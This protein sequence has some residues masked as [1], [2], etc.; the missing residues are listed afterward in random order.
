MNYLILALQDKENELN[1]IYKNKIY[2]PRLIQIIDN[3]LEYVSFRRE[4][5][6]D[7]RGDRF[8]NEC[9]VHG[10]PRSSCGCGRSLDTH[11]QFLVGKDIYYER[12]CLYVPHRKSGAKSFV[13][14]ELALNGKLIFLIDETE[15]RLV[16]DGKLADRWHSAIPTTGKIIFSDESE[17]AKLY[18]IKLRNESFYYMKISYIGTYI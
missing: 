2:E 5:P 14:R 12:I 4:H 8:P 3:Y 9:I 6:F 11:R 17:V 13:L 1:K 7:Y 15:K 18:Y 10:T 16:I